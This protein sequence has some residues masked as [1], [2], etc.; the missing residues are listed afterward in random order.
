MDLN[1]VM[2]AVFFIQLGVKVDDLLFLLDCVV[3]TV[4]RMSSIEKALNGVLID[5]NLLNLGLLIVIGKQSQKARHLLLKSSQ[6][7]STLLVQN[8]HLHLRLAL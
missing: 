7:Q 1:L 4:D 8:T 5:Q 6:D 2:S 3:E